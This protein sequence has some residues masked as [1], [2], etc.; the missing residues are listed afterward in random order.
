MQP[1]SLTPHGWAIL[2]AFILALREETI[3]AL[4]ANP[5]PLMVLDDPQTSFDPRNKRKWA[6]EL[7]RLANIDQTAAE[8]LQLFLTTHERQFYQYVVDVEHLKGE[9]GLIGGVN[10]TSGVAKIV[11]ANWLQQIWLEANENNNDARARDYIRE[12]HIY[13]EDLLKFMVRGEGPTIP[14]FTLGA[15]RN[16]LKRLHDAH[17]PPFDRKAFSDLIKTLDGG[18]GRPM[19]LINEA[20]HKDK[21]S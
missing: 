18:G 5:F 9:Q 2:W 20:H 12:V 7:A 14:D 17:V 8:G 16:E 15:L 13:C 6:E 19:I 4:D 10:K 3:E 11:N 21:E 1:W